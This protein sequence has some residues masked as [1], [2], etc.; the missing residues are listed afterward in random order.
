MLRLDENQLRVVTP[1]VGGGF[2]A[3]FIMYPEEVTLGR[4]CLLPAA[5]GQ[6]DRRPA[7]AFSSPRSR[8]ATSTG[9]VDV[10]FDDDGRLLGV[11]GEMIHDEGAYTP[12]GI[13]LPYNVIHRAA[14]PLHAAAPI[15][16]TSRGR[17]QQGRHHAGAA[18]RGYP[19]GCFRDGTRCS[20]ASRDELGPRSRG[21]PAPQSRCRRKRC[22][23]CRRSRRSAGSPLALDSGDFL[24]LP[25]PGAARRS[26]MPAFRRAS[27]RAR[28]EGRYL[29]IGLGNGVKGT[30]RGPFE[31]GD[32]ARSAAPARISVCDR[33]DAH[34][35]R[36]QD[37]RS[38]R[39]ARSS[40][41]SRRRR[42]S[43][44][45]RGDT[46]IIPTAMGGFASRQTVTAGSA[47]HLAAR[48]GA[49]TRR[50][51][52]PP[53]LLGGEREPISNCATG[54]SRSPARPGVAG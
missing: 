21:S 26:T 28:V 9:I 14:R 15:S 3:K 45:P 43:R 33:R 37:R 17:D 12:Q 2:G 38:R 6:V 50:S 22:R 52:S 39:S 27:N 47:V 41:A 23:M 35:A 53:T 25:A 24:G 7:R 16:S 29:G 49:A 5:A 20:T 54:G 10:A 13:N 32:R 1:D 8:S 11:R 31:S 18:A 36:D 44:W 40:S 30:G 48:R 51:R 19:E 42:A 34:G 46:A 4:S